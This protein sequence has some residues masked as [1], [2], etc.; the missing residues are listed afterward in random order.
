MW[1]RLAVV[2]Y[3]AAWTALLLIGGGLW[4]GRLGDVAGPGFDD[5]PTWWWTCAVTA[6]LAVLLIGLGRFLSLR[7]GRRF[8]FGNI[9]FVVWL[10]LSL[11]IL[12]AFCRRS[13][14]A[15]PAR[16]LHG[17]DP[18]VSRRAWGRGLGNED[19]G[20]NSW[21]QRDLERTI[22]PTRGVTRIAFIGDSFLEE[23]A[24]PV[25]L[26]ADR[27]LNR[28]DCEIVNLGVSATQPDEYYYR[29]RSV[30]LPLGCRQCVVWIFSG[31]DF[32]DERRTLAG[33]WGFCAVA[34]RTAWL[35]NLGCGAIN[36]VLM[37]EQRPVIQAWLTSG[38][39]AARE[40]RLH[41]QFRRASDYEIQQQMLHSGGHTPTTYANLK[42]RLDAPEI[43]SFFEM[44]RTPDAGKFRSYY[45]TSALLAAASGGG[46]WDRNP[47]EPALYWVTE[48]QRLCERKSVQLTV[49]IIP[50]A[51]QVDD[52]LRDLWSPL[53]D[54]RHV[55]Q[56]CRDAAE[57][58]CAAA[59]ER[60]I[61]VLDLHE[62]FQ[63]VPGTY[64]NL[65]GHWSQ[66]GVELAAK[67]IADHIQNQTMAR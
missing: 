25:S 14:P 47:E 39:L 43:S 37:N 3:F 38:G 19:V 29:L 52:R 8:W 17:V 22:H 31:N 64:L 62:T 61:D 12:E 26:T 58:F 15:W 40:Q 6:G 16:A 2:A 30:A 57:R 67:A 46:Q 27:M 23:S 56:P 4:T 5:R 24:Q 45:L 18:A 42:A 41:D 50:E 36:H 11:G 28:S 1:I 63:N 54:M 9:L 21:G 32:V 65:D 59:R 60:G 7:Q 66:R 35:T 55:T 53:A 44:L 33:R 49:V 51:F 34:P 10:P 13:A 48:M 20:F